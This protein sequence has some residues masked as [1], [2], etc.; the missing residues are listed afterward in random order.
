MDWKYAQPR[1]GWGA[2]VM[3]GAGISL[4]TALLQTKAAVWLAT[5]FIN[6]FSLMDAAFL[7][8]MAIMSLFLILIHLD[9]ASRY[10]ISFRY[11]SYHNIHFAKSANSRC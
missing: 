10:G 6:A 1:I 9:F 2:I 4:G 7:G 3:F 8:L 11:D 5:I